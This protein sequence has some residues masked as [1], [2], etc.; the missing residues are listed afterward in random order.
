[1]KA[2]YFLL[3][4]LCISP[5]TAEIKI[6]AFAGSTRQDSLNKKLVI[7]AANI[8]KEKGATV[9]VVDLK[10]YPI[11]LYDGDL[12]KNSGMPEFA[13]QLRRLMIDSQAIIIATPE[14]N[15]SI[16]AVLKNALDW[17]SRDENGHSSRDAFK[18]KIFA[19]M[20]ASPGKGGGKRALNHL[21]T[22]I[23]AVGGQ[24]VSI[25]TSVPEAATA[26]DAH[27]HL[28]ENPSKEELKKEVNQLLLNN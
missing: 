18:G 4:L 8:A 24:V 21:R 12:E 11:P 14:Y 13:K 19:I 28:K 6:V 23:E 15:G 25:Q 22:I 3:A 5:L 7:E 27:G 10:D 9:T 17:A 2:L 1:M 20:S 26:F 16:P